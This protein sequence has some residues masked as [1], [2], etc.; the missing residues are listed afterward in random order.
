MEQYINQLIEDIQ[1]A[2]RPESEHVEEE[3]STFLADDLDDLD[4]HFA[5]I[6]RYT[7][8]EGKT[9]LGSNIGLEEVQF[10]PFERITEE[11]MIRVCEAF[12]QCLFTWNIT[13]EMPQNLPISL[14]YKTLIST[15]KRDVFIQSSGF[16]HLEFCHYDSENCPFGLEFCECKNI[17]DE[18]RN[19]EKYKEIDGELP[20]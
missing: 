7:S 20:F 6:E 5:D 18:Y 13:A 15:L 9:N 8:G 19:F 17:E 12:H 11:Q 1:N 16:I 14:R 4:T 3:E 2:Q 10:P